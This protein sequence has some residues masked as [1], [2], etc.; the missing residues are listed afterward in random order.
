MARGPDN[1]MHI[2]TRLKT[3][4]DE[5]RELAAII[6]ALRADNGRLLTALLKKLNQDDSDDSVRLAE[7]LMHHPKLRDLVPH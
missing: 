4:G 2:Y 7:V 5:E 6:D 3:G 1:V